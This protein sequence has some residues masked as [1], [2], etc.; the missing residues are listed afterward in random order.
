MS[1][2]TGELEAKNVFVL[3]CFRETCQVS[4]GRMSLRPNFICFIV[5][6]I[7]S[8]PCFLSLFT[9]KRSYRS[10]AGRHP[11]S[12]KDFTDRIK[13]GLFSSPPAGAAASAAT[14]SM[15]FGAQ[16]VNSPD[17]PPDHV[18]APDFAGQYVQIITL[19]YVC[20]LRGCG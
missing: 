6:T 17:L 16:V 18:L 1:E 8:C 3:E 14:G 15:S 4:V 20:A 5:S 11:E 9:N 7:H 19:R 13:A 2:I 10:G 12:V